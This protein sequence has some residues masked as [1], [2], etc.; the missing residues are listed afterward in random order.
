MM[1][2]RENRLEGRRILVV[3]DEYLLA[4]QVSEA[5]RDQGAE[6]LGPVADPLAALRT[7]CSDTRID[8]AVL[9]INLQG[10][11][12]YPVAFELQQRG[13]PMV[14]ATGYADAII[15]EALAG[16]PLCSKPVDAER[17]GRLIIR[18]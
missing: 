1:N 5:L 16:V 15:P 2:G 9:D 4:R 7:I 10:E 11:M 13:V 6:V 8:G 18:A 12:V 3:E 17:V 14:F